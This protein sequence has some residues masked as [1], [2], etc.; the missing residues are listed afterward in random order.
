MPTKKAKT[1]R[2]GSNLGKGT[3]VNG[4]ETLCEGVPLTV[5]DENVAPWSLPMEAL[6][7]DPRPE[8]II[9]QFKNGDRERKIYC[10]I[11][12][13]E[14]ELEQ[15]NGLRRESNKRQWLPSISIMA[16]RFL[17]RARGDAKKAVDLMQKTQDWRLEYFK[18]GPV[19]DE[20]VI[21]DLKHGIVYFTGRDRS[22]R[23]TLVI[24]ANRIPQ[25]WYKEK[26]VDKLIRILIFCMEYMLRYMLVPGRVENN[27]VIVDLKGLGISQV[28]IGALKE[29]YGIMSHHY[30]G[31]VYKF[32]ICNMSGT[33]S[34]VAGAAKA[35]LTDRQKQKL[36]IL[37]N[38]DE[39]QKEFARH[40]L[41][42][43]LGGQRPQI[44]KFFPFPLLAGP[45]E[46]GYT[47]GPNTK[48][49]KRADKALLPEG[50]LGR[51]WDPEVSKEENV[52]LMYS[53][54]APEIFRRSNHPLPPDVI[55]IEE[56]AKKAKEAEAAKAAEFEQPMSKE[57]IDVN[58]V[59]SNQPNANDSAVLQP[60][61]G[62]EDGTPHNKME[63]VLGDHDDEKESSD[64]ESVVQEF[65]SV[66]PSGFFSCCS[67][68]M[69]SH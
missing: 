16:G 8:D 40:H 3:P 12:L 61:F 26:S 11:E 15:I 2:S 56:A 23:P 22:L 36:C 44:Q 60:I 62:T 21:E 49:E 4:F 58:N 47:D 54:E 48:S 10:S 32:Y 66:K 24:R 30:I 28:P 1:R 18:G 35:I 45:F 50:F 17:S 52:K 25:Q 34:M 43:D 5:K 68:C 20:S 38:N 37:S 63:E 55:A 65:V 13:T 14:T 19:A 41:E 42:E 39:L 33:L 29:V 53:P 46:G 59:D 69:Y 31:R 57:T 9:T 7:Y 67:P 64:N 51:L 27:C 6:T